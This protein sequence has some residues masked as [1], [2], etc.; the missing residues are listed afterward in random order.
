MAIY[1]GLFLMVEEPDVSRIEFIS[2]TASYTTDDDV[3]DLLVSSLDYEK[4]VKDEEVEIQAVKMPPVGPGADSFVSKLALKLDL[5][6][7]ECPDRKGDDQDVYS[8][9]LHSSGSFP[10]FKAEWNLYIDDVIQEINSRSV[11]P[12]NK[13]TIKT[14]G[15]WEYTDCVYT[16]NY[17]SLESSTGG[18]K[19]QVGFYGITVLYQPDEQNGLVLFRRYELEDE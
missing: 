13:C 9:Y 14:L 6:K 2:P 15:T 17:G 11:D 5:I 3:R 1:H 19:L 18:E 7:I 8:C 10:L 16:R 4:P 12:L